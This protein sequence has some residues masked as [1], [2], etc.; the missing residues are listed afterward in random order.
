[1]EASSGRLVSFSATL[2][3]STL[4]LKSEF[5]SLNLELTN[6]ARLAGSELQRSTRLCV[7]ALRLETRASVPGFHMGAEDSN[8]RPCS[9]VQQTPQLLPI[10]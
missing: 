5:L 4:F 10:S 3:L 9:R 1:M 2:S 6:L 8:S 7:L